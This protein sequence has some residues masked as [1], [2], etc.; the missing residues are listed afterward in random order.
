[1]AAQDITT[2]AIEGCSKP[3]NAK[4]FCSKHYAKYR[5]TGNPV[6][7]SKKFRYTIETCSVDGCKS[8]AVSRYFCGKHYQRWRKHKD[9]LRVAEKSRN[10]A[11]IQPRTGQCKADN[12]TSQVRP[13]GSRGYCGKHYYRYLNYGDPFGGN[14]FFTRSKGE[15]TINNGYHFKTVMIDG[16]KRSVGVHRLVMERMLGRKLRSNENVHHINGNRSDNRIENLELWVRTQPCGQ[17]P[18]DLVDWAET[19]LDLYGEEVKK[20][21]R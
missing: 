14:R 6:A 21:A 3:V 16:K 2:C 18:K 12:C 19:I 5:K 17:R 11:V 10:G 7:K 9:P 13:N 1:M 4:G 8:P 15:G 20:H